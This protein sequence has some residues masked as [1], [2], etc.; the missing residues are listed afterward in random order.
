MA[1]GSLQWFT[2]AAPAVEKH[3][4]V[5]TIKPPKINKGSMV[6]GKNAWSQ[7]KTKG[8]NSKAK[9]FDSTGKN[10]ENPK[11]V[12]WSGKISKWWKP[13]LRSKLKIKSPL[14]AYDNRTLQLSLLNFCFQIDWL[15]CLKSRISLFLP[16]DCIDTGSG[17]T[18]CRTLR[19]NNWVIAN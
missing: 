16:N 8:K 12:W 5:N 2:L 1:L 14:L 15:T 10:P 6:F 4:Y 17:L 7:T 9:I 3:N 11:N 18:T 19:H 13:D